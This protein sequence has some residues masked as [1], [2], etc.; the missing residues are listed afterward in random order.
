VFID[1]LTL[2]RAS[3]ML[4]SSDDPLQSDGQAIDANS[5]PPF[6]IVDSS[7]MQHIIDEMEA[8]GEPEEE[9][10]FVNIIMNMVRNSV[11]A[12]CALVGAVTKA[13]CCELSIASQS[14]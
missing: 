4:Y 2:L 3:V 12:P 8:L 6:R 11:L 9:G 5:Y 14:T 1:V 13:L 7:V 10:Q